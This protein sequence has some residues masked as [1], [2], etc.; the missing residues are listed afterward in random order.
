MVK[1]ISILLVGSIVLSTAIVSCQKTE[2]AIEYGCKEKCNSMYDGTLLENE[3]GGWGCLTGVEGY[4]YN[5]T[6]GQC[7]HRWGG[8][9]KT[10]GECTDCG[11]ED[12]VE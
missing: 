10:M 11:C 7:E 2:Q 8:P 4:V 5:S 1:K 12:H 6:T 9:F 3:S